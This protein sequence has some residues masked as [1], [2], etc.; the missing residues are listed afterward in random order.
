[1]KKVIILGREGRGERIAAIIKQTKVAE[2]LGFLS[3]FDEPGTTIGSI[4][5]GAGQRVLGN[6][7][8]ITK[9]LNEDKSL[10]VING[11]PTGYKTPKSFLAK[12]HALNIPPARFMNAVA[13]SA[14]IYPPAESIGKSV[15]LNDYALVDPK[16]EIAD[17]VTLNPFAMAGHGCKIGEFSQ[18]SAKSFVGAFCNVG[19]GVHIEV[20]AC[21]R[22]DINI[23]DYAI[24]GMGAVVVKDVPAYSVVVGNPARVLRYRD[25]NK[26]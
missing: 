2:V 12:L 1:M 5:N 20:S 11:I 24:V 25:E 3:D 9:Y 4:E 13:P 19:K 10:C 8:D 17:F 6:L 26:L 21:I 16:V 22:E 15:L 14:V 7:N 23:G 18:L